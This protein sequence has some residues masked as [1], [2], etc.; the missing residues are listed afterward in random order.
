MNVLTTKKALS[1]KAFG[2]LDYGA[3][4]GNRREIKG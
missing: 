2:Y 1:I 3:G 4:E